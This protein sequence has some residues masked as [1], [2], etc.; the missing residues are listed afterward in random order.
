MIM[1][2]DDKIVIYLSVKL[3]LGEERRL[4]NEIRYL[5]REFKTGFKTE[6]YLKHEGMKKID[7]IRLYN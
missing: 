3:S 7:L 1:E 5:L 6:H 2:K 4:L